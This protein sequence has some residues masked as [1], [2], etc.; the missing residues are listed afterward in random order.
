MLNSAI[1]MGR[2]VADPE[3]KKTQNDVSY[4]KF[5]LAVDRDFCKKDEEKKTDFIDI[6]AWR[7][8]AEFVC[9]YFKKSSLAVIKGSVQV[10][11]YTD[12]KGNKRK[13]FEIKADEVYF[14]GSKGKGEVQT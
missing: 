9:K 7:N 5:T 4:T 13:V 8:T 6:V 2:F 3:L 1:L 12:T 11:N 10:C 14:A